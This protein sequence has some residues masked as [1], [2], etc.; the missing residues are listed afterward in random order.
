M[1]QNKIFRTISVVLLVGLHKINRESFITSIMEI[2]VN[3]SRMKSN[4][5]EVVREEISGFKIRSE[6]YPSAE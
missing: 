4:T 1:V 3:F 2:N 6:Y 5:V